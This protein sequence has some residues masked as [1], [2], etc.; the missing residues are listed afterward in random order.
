[1]RKMPWRR[2]C[3]CRAIPVAATLGEGGAEGGRGEK[4]A[5]CFFFFIYV[6]GILKFCSKIRWKF[7]TNFATNLTFAKIN[8]VF[9]KFVEK[10]VENFQRIFQRILKIPYFFRQMLNSLE[11]SNEFSK[12]LI[13]FRKC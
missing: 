9:L 6:C 4:W 12:H 1:M 5:S 3:N 8:K 2:V 10:F 13:F 7:P 11:I